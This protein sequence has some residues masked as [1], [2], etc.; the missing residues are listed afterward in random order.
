M[1]EAAPL[2]NPGVFN[3]NDPRGAE[4]AANQAAYEHALGT[5]LAGDTETLQNERT[6]AA[7]QRSLIAKQEPLSFRANENKANAE[8]L[9][10]SGVN[11]GRRGNL[12]A[13]FISKGTS[14]SQKMT[15][16]EAR[17]LA[18]DNIARESEQSDSAK[19]LAAYN[20]DKLRWE[21]E[22]PVVAP[23]PAVAAP[24]ASAPTVPPGVVGGHPQ[25]VSGSVPTPIKWSRNAAVREIQR[26]RG[27]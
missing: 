17:R 5:T 25:P 8:G 23:E 11:A 18:S 21:Q 1:A 24:T 22:H 15:Q 12:Q 27:Y 6:N 26:R 7:Y 9:L 16:A 10:E 14:V 4:F 2:V 19:N 13:D 3:Q 20:N